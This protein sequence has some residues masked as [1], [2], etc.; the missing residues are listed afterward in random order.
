MKDWWTRSFQK[1]LSIGAMHWSSVK[2]IT[3]AYCYTNP[4]AFTTLMS[5]FN[6]IVLQTKIATQWMKRVSSSGIAPCD[7]RPK[8][9]GLIYRQVDCFKMWQP[10]K[11]IHIYKSLVHCCLEW[12]NRTI[13]FIVSISMKRLSNQMYWSNTTALLGTPN[14]VKYKLKEHGSQWREENREDHAKSS[15][16]LKLSSVWALTSSIGS[17]FYEMGSL[18][19]KAAF[20][21]SKRKQRW[22]NLKSC[23]RRFRSVG[24]WENSACGKTRR[25]WNML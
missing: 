21:W 7:W 11:Y 16:R 18:T 6:F 3:P 15:S 2:T 20:R 9:I 22:R 8:L 12:S 23:P 10:A 19:E 1:K 5:K 17:L 24:S 25:P 14:Y 13:T 4:F